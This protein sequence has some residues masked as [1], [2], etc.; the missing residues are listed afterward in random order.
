MKLPALALAALL[1][2]AALPALAAPPDRPGTGAGERPIQ[3]A[4]AALPGALLEEAAGLSERALAGDGAWTLLES[5]TTEVGPR[6]AGTA[7]DRAA[8]AWA[9]TTLSGLGFDSVRP[10]SVDVPRWERGQI[11]AVIT[12]PFPQPLAATALGGSPGTSDEGLEAP[13]LMVEDVA[14]LEALKPAAVAG[15]I[16]FFN[17]RMQRTRDSSSYD[18]VVRNRYYGPAAAAGLGA[19]AAL[20][21]SAGTGDDRFPHTG[22]TRFKEP[23]AAIPAVAISNPDADLLARQLGRGDGATVRLKLTARRL[24]RARSANVIADVRGATRPG[25]IVILGA[26]LDSWDLGTGAV[27]NGAGVAVV[28]EAARL[29]AAMERRPARTVRVVLFANEEFGL[30]GAKAYA[31]ARAEGSRHVVGLESD[32]GAGPIYRLDA[33][34]PDDRL[35]RVAALFPLLEPL[36]IAGG[37]TRERKEGGADLKPLRNL[38]MP[39]LQLR[40]DGSRYFD[41]HHTA[42]DTLDKVDPEALAR[43]V[44]AYASVAWVAANMDGDF[45]DLGPLEPQAPEVSPGSTTTR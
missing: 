28:V 17:K 29:V 38:G 33:V 20:V 41:L 11:E 26:H 24:G 7:G 30:D 5:L 39:E 6:L 36:G 31:A 25:E 2:P 44:A 18:V 8:V 32:F 15:H 1:L 35:D 37:F 19:V 42:N 34:V 13:V 16:V 21:R 9:L 12:S 10:Q 23:E 14:A 3:A 4:P 22:G 40:Q 45:G 43:L 27:D